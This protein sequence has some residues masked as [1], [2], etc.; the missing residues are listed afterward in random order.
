[1]VWFL[2]LFV[3]EVLV[4]EIVLLHCLL[5]WYTFSLLSESVQSQS[6]VSKNWAQKA[7]LFLDMGWVMS[8]TILFMSSSAAFTHMVTAG[9]LNRVKQY[10]MCE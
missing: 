7:S 3:Y 4:Y 1:M 6:K 2:N 10:R 8:P 9:P 5:C